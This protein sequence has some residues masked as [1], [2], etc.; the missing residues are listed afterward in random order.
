MIFHT[1]CDGYLLQDFLSGQ[2][3]LRTQ[4]P[5]PLKKINQTATIK[6]I[7]KQ[8]RHFNIVKKEATGNIHNILS[9]VRKERN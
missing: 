7:H 2:P 4:S 6:T 9:K 3:N 8:G 5:L 1:C